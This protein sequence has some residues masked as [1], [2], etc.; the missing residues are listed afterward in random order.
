MVMSWIF[1]G[2]LG[3]SLIAAAILGNGAAL[4]AA[5]PQC[6]QAGITRAISMAGSL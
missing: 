3:I 6:A 5:V 2:L 1:A 4:A